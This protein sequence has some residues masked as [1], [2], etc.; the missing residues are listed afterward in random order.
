MDRIAD[1]P[2]GSEERTMSRWIKRGVSTVVLAYFAWIALNFWTGPIG[3][4]ETQDLFRLAVLAGDAGS[5]RRISADGEADQILDALKSR[6]IDKP[7]EIIMR[8][9]GYHISGLTGRTTGY[10]DLTAR[11]PD[12][13][14]VPF[15]LDLV[16][17]NIFL[18]YGWRI[19]AIKF[20]K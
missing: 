11:L 18:S 17:G 7:G 16:K 1:V 2:S 9:A 12:G 10:Y 20:D 8:G 3:W 13:A 19:A 5:I 14:S 4:I 15:R 6:K